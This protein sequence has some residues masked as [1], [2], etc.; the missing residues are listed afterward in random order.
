MGFFGTL[1][2]VVVGVGSVALNAAL[3]MGEQANYI[4]NASGGMSNQ[5][6]INGIKDKHSSL[7]EK[8]GY[9]AALKDRATKK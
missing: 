9:Y 4:R 5:D 1:G 3:N 2:K 7:A 6:L 8:T